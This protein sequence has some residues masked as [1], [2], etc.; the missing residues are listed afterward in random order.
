MITMHAYLGD[1][2]QST[3]SLADPRDTPPLLGPIS[4][5]F[6]Q[7]SGKNWPNSRLASLP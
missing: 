6:M 1:A 4:F 7:F 5:N 3:A 2:V